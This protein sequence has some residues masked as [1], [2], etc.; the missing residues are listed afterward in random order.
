MSAPSLNGSNLFG[1][2]VEKEGG[3]LSCPFDNSQ[4]C[5][6]V[7]AFQTKNG[8]FWCNGEVSSLLPA[9]SSIPPL[10]QLPSPLS[11]LLPSTDSNPQA[12][13]FFSFLSG[14]DRSYEGELLG[15]SL[16]SLDNHVVVR[17]KLEGN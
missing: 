15:Y 16:R 17:D 11:P 6:I 1:G 8:E 5:H 3:V 2:P 10:H 13:L 14:D 9:T 12:E 4:S 7:P